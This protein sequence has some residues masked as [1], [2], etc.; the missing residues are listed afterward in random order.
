MQS[1]NWS[2]G[3][4]HI[5]LWSTAGT[6]ARVSL[7][8]GRNSVTLYSKEEYLVELQMCV[9]AEDIPDPVIEE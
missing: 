5:D 3:L 8:A 2:T 1:R 9:L 4:L 6:I 7:D